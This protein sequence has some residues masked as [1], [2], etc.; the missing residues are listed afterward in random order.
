MMKEYDGYDVVDWCQGVS[1]SS[2]EVSLV[3]RLL[4]GGER[5]RAW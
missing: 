5:K 2:L 1:V 3:P 4:C